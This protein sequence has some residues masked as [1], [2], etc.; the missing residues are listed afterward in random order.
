MNGAPNIERGESL[1]DLLG[2][3]PAALAFLA[4]ILG[5]SGLIIRKR[6]C[7]IGLSLGLVSL[8]CLGV[9]VTAWR[10]FSSFGVLSPSGAVDPMAFAYTTGV[11]WLPV[12]I[13]LPAC[14]AGFALLS[15]A[16]L[17]QKQNK[18]DQDDA[19]QRPC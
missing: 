4:V 7:I 13:V 19:S 9:G 15:I 8:A 1:F 6:T 3:Y 16:S 10:F 5:I 18:P 14:G 17:F 11:S 2:L 12:G